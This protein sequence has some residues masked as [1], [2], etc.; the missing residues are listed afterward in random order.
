MPR[1]AFKYITIE[2]V[3]GAGKTSLASK[4]CDWFG[5]HLVLEEFETNP[6]LK[7]FYKDQ[8]RYAFQTQIFFLLSRFKQQEQL[9]QY[10]LFHEKTISDYMFQKDRIFATSNLIDAEMKLYD[11]LARIMEQQIAVPDFV[12]YLQASTPRL[13][14]NIRRRGRDYEREMSVEYIDS[15]NKLYESF[16]AHY[17]KTP[18]IT[19]NMDDMDFINSKTDFKK[20]LDLI[21]Q[22]SGNK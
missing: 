18:L 12:L 15:L 9:R 11:G 6:F 5:A 8:R 7:D 14:D 10:D 20:V 17:S 1:A 19:I 22:Q 13:M 21:N 2:G 16:F 4:L 3:I